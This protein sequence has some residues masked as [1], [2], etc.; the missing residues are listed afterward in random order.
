MDRTNHVLVVES[1]T[2]C[3]E[4]LRRHHFEVLAFTDP[5][6]AFH[7]ATSVDAVVVHLTATDDA[8]PRT[9]LVRRLQRDVTTQ[10]LPILIAIT[11]RP[12]R[13]DT[14]PVQTFG[15]ALIVLT[16]ATCDGVAAVLHDLLDVERHHT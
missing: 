10:H 4:E 2:K 8:D 7:A 16:N 12:D 5:E 3:A 9:T 11:G 1:A 15:G 14:V 13:A 6:A